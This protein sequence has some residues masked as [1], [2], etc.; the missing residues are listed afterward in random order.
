MFL[1]ERVMEAISHPSMDS[2]VSADAS[3]YESLKINKYG[4]A[5]EI[6]SLSGRSLD[7][8]RTVGVLLWLAVPEIAD[9]VKLLVAFGMGGYQTLVWSW[10]L[11]SNP[12]L[13]E[14]CLS[15]SSN[16]FLMVEFQSPGVVPYPHVT[17]SD[18]D[19]KRRTVF[20]ILFD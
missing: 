18:I 5:A 3:Q 4:D 19:L 10:I 16:R 11:D 14:D 8:E 7:H 1:S 6:T 17:F 9:N 13:I 2:E 20:D 15:V 12:K